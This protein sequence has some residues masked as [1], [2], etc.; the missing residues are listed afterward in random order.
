MEHQV[1]LGTI[2]AE[3]RRMGRHTPVGRY[4]DRAA[5]ALRIAGELRSIGLLNSARKALAE[6]REHAAVVEYLLA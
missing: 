1:S 3:I 5:T 2:E 6:A 4:M